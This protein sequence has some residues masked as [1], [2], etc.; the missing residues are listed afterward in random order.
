MEST[1]YSA[2]KKRYDRFCTIGMA[3]PVFHAIGQILLQ[4][5]LKF[6][7]A[8]KVFSGTFGFGMMYGSSSLTSLLF[9][10]GNPDAKSIATVSSVITIALVMA[11]IFLSSAMIKG[12]KTMPLVCL[13]LYG[14]DVLCAIAAAVVSGLHVTALTMSVAEMSILL[15][16]HVLC[17]CV[18]GYLFFVRRRLND[19]EI[20]E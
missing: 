18:Y 4:S 15:F 10:N 16:C 9:A 1:T 6:D 2:L 3:I 14:V 13:S 20:D 7:S 19:F 8:T 12:N 11:F 5:F 17:L